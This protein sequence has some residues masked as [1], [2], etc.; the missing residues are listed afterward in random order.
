[1]DPKEV[2]NFLSHPNPNNDNISNN[3]DLQIGIAEKDEAK[4]QELAPKRSSNKDRH[5]KVEGRGRRIRMPALCAARIFQLTR[6]LGHKS[7]GETIQWLLQQAEPSIIAATGNGTIPASALAA[8]GPSVSQQGISEFNSRSSWPMVIGN[9]GRPPSGPDV[10]NF[11][12]NLGTGSASNCLQ[13][14]SFPGFDP[15][16]NPMSFASMLGATNP[17]QLPGLELGLSQEGHIGVM[18]SQSLNQ[19]YQQMGHS[20]MQHHSQ[21]QQP[22]PEDDNSQGPGQ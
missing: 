1:M 17:Q 6:E 19:I 8:A 12:H 10:S 2:S 20:R 11:G 7:D 13:K 16:L 15:N 4:K 9:F 21:Q 14:I 5:T 22:S 3:N 18:N